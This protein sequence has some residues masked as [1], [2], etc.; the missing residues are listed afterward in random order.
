M[1]TLQPG[2]TLASRVKPTIGG[3]HQM[4]LAGVPS[5]PHPYLSALTPNP[6]YVDPN[7]PVPVGMAR[8]FDLVGVTP[9]MWQQMLANNPLYAVS[10]LLVVSVARLG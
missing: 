9:E 2:L 5:G 10:P 1:P 3:I 6:S 8:P 4:N 7:A